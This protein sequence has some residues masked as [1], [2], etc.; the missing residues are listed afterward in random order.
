[1]LLAEANCKRQ[2][3]ADFRKLQRLRLEWHETP[4]PGE[5]SPDW[6]VEQ[7]LRE[8]AEKYNLTYGTD[9]IE[10]AIAVEPV[11]VGTLRQATALDRSDSPVVIV[12]DNPKVNRLDLEVTEVYPE[13]DGTFKIKVSPRYCRVS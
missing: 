10:E 12:S 9:Q 3:I 13:T 8:I 11:T 1:M 2:V 4:N 7:R 5:R 6:F